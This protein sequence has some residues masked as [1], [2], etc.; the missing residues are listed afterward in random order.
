[1]NKF[2]Y[3]Q[4]IDTLPKLVAAG[5]Q[6]LGVK[7]IPGARS[8]PVIIDMAKGLGIEKI[9]T[10]DDT[11]WC[12]L[13]MSHLFRITGKPLLGIKG[14][15]YNYLRAAKYAEWGNKVD[16]PEMGDVLVFSRT[17]GG[18]VGLYVGESKY[19]YFV[20]GGNQS[21]SVSITEIKKDRLTAARRYY[22]TEP[23]ASVKKYIL[24]STGT[25]SINE[26]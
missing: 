24:D 18:H 3:L 2:P 23:P 13:F 14:D 11:A 15:K 5:L 26:A 16:E 4:T 20:L 25:V 21:N 22:A 9:Y 19:T 7:E 12:G 6:Y 10:N 8:N 1:M 17:G